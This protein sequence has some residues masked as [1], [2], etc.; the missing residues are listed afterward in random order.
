MQSLRAFDLIY[1][2]TYGGPGRST[3]VLSTWMY[4]NLFQYQ[5][6]GVGSAIAWVIVAVSLLVTIPYI[7]MVARGRGV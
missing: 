2:M 5:Q 1:T 4:F 6:A 3:H 7:R